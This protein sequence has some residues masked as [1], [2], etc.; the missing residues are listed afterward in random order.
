MENA[1]RQRD[2]GRAIFRNSIVV[3]LGG[4][5]FR[6]ASLAFSLFAI[7]LLGEVEFGRYST[8]IAFCGIFGVFFELG[9]S[10]YAQRT[11]AQDR[12]RV[13]ELFWNLVA[14]RLVLALLGCAAIVSLSRFLGHAP[15]VTFGVFL[16]TATYLP[17]A[18]LTPLTVLLTADE[19][20]TIPTA[21]HVGGQIVTIAIGLGMLLL[22]HGFLALLYSGWIVMPLQIA[23]CA[24][25]VIRHRLGPGPFQVA[26]SAWPDLIRSSVPFGLTA[27]ALTYNFN[28][29]AVILGHWHGDATVGWYSAAYRLVFNFVALLGGFLTV[30][31]P[32]LSREYVSDPER[33]GRVVRFSIQGLALFSL[34][35]AVG[36]SLLAHPLVLLL[37]GES[38]APSGPILALICWDVPLLLFN[39]FAG[40]VTAAMGLERPAAKIYLTSAIINVGLNLLLIPTFGMYAAVAATLISDGLS[41][42]RFYVLLRHRSELGRIA[43]HLTRTALAALLMGIIVLATRTVNLPVSIACGMLAYGALVV[44]LRLIDPVALISRPRQIFGTI[45]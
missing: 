8:V 35:V 33:V 25:V 12:S 29:D 20:F 4:V 37:Y 38:Y 24:W 19:R 31:T 41:A 32:T 44:A 13:T 21:I 9:L 34:P 6:V 17:A 10:Q 36:V 23:V 26:L 11:L 28:A 45:S 16:M 43:S 22:G 42:V 14:V 5:V 2:V 27:I 3:T 15:E 39:A 1:P 7:R 18:F 40:N 30:I